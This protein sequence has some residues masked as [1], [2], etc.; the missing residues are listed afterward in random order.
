MA[1]DQ[2]I[3]PAT[4][5]NKGHTNA[6]MHGAS[7]P[8]NGNSCTCSDMFAKQLNMPK[9]IA[10]NFWTCTDMCKHC[11]QFFGG[12]D[13]ELHGH[14]LKVRLLPAV[15]VHQIVPSCAQILHRPVHKPA[16][17]V[18]AARAEHAVPAAHALPAVTAAAAAGALAAC[19]AADALAAAAAALA[20]AA[21]VLTL[22]A[23]CL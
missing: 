15:Q 21:V 5:V 2:K 16:A 8:Q 3:C 4:C 12:V 19:A 23:D 7:T 6:S 10:Y 9:D 22:A 20:H 11:I 14:Y 13:S 18:Q 17:A 1:N